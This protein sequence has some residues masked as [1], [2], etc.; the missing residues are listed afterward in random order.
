MAKEK[1]SSR[2]WPEHYQYLVYVAERSGNSEQCVL[3][4]LCKSAPAY[5]QRAMLTRLNSQ[6]MDHLQQAAELVSFAIEYE[7]NTAK[8]GN[9]NGCS[10]SNRG[11][12]G[13]GG[14]GHGSGNGD[15][16]GRGGGFVARSG[17]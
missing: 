5:L 3:Q 16:N 7:A 2:S 11:G 8:L 15:Q 12:H 1:I 4:C 17:I 10:K 6:R 9:G 14:R 13:R